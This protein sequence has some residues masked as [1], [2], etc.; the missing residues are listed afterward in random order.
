MKEVFTVLSLSLAGHQHHQQQ[1][2]QHQQQQSKSKHS[3]VTAP[4][5]VATSEPPSAPSSQTAVPQHAD[6][7]TSSKGSLSWFK[8]ICRTQ[9]PFLFSDFSIMR[10]ISRELR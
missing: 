5:P 1:Q 3:G 9:L 2:Q 6:A 8:N 7:K 10:A 4:P